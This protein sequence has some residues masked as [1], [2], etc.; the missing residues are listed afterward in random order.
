MPVENVRMLSPPGQ[1][2]CGL[3]LGSVVS[4]CVAGDI[5]LS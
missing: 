1:D 3:S 5:P 2:V 4:C